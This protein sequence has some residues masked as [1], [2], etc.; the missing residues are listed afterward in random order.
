[1]DLDFDCNSLSSLEDIDPQP[2]TCPGPSLH[3]MTSQTTFPVRLHAMLSEVECDPVLSKMVSWRPH[4][5]LFVVEDR[6]GF[7]TRILPRYVHASLHRINTQRSAQTVVCYLVAQ[8]VCN[9]KLRI[10]SAS[11]QYVRL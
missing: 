3:L 1:M 4:G 2:S 6:K 5:R 10:F 8:L 11:V 7:M 9:D